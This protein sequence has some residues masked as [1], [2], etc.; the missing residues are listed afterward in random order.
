MI[1]YGP[2]PVVQ[3]ELCVGTKTVP[4]VRIFP[5]YHAMEGEWLKAL[6]RE[7]LAEA[8][9]KFFAE[10]KVGVD[11][12]HLLQMHDEFEADGL[13]ENLPHGAPVCIHPERA[14]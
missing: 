14:G 9:L 4:W 3:I 2:G 11:V 1:G 10:G 7:R 12:A 5:P 6:P 8:M 13:F